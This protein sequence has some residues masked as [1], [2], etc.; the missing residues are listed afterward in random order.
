MTDVE[1]KRV[2]LICCTVTHLPVAICSC[3]GDR[4]SEE[5]VI[6]RREFFLAGTKGK[7]REKVRSKKIK[8]CYGQFVLGSR[9]DQ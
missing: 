8:T 7:L 6:R 4:N 9:M 3:C 1:G 5:T 2:S